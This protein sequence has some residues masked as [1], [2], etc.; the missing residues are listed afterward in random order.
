MSLEQHPSDSKQYCQLVMRSDGESKASPGFA[1]MVV[2]SDFVQS[3]WGG[4]GGLQQF[5]GK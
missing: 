2:D 3:E 1:H 5:K 4:G